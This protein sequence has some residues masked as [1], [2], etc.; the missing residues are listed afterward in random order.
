MI[1]GFQVGFWLHGTKRSLQR[2]GPEEV[3]ISIIADAL[4]RG[5]T[6]FD[7]S[8][9]YGPEVNDILAGKVVHKIGILKSFSRVMNN[10]AEERI[11]KI[12]MYLD[13]S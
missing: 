5:I 8:N 9:V 4:A 12:S 10:G 13:I 6:F 7:T 11:V 1:A 3:G 2:S